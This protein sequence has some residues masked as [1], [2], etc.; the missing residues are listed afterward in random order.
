MSLRGRYV[1]DRVKSV[2]G[3]SFQLPVPPYADADYWNAAYRSFGPND[4]F[5]W[6]DVSLEDLITYEHKE[7]NWET[8][9]SNTQP[10]QTSLAETLGIHPNGSE[11]EPILMLG[12][13]NSRLGEQ[14]MESGWKGPMIQV[15]VSGQ[16]IENMNQ[17]CTDLVQAGR[18]SFIKDDA[19]E[20][21][22]FRNDMIS[23]CLDKGLIDAVFCA[24]EYAQCQSVLKSVHRV[25]QPGGVFAF[26]SFSRP[27]F[28]LPKIVDSDYRKNRAL[29]QHVQ[30]QELSK[31]MLYK[32]Q[33]VDAPVER[34]VSISRPSSRKRK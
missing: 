31:I 3:S 21:S 9:R 26:L 23:A 27:Q 19:A 1:I 33:K 6:G 14:M 13:G 16:V 29:W 11:E 34:K 18:M 32:F 10:I 25:L 22:A 12:C 24:D 28:L 20:L 4:S 8:G 30:V 2:I 17:R 7:L 15:D 5:E